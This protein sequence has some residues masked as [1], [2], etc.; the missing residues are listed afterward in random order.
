MAPAKGGDALTVEP[1]EEKTP[2]ADCDVCDEAMDLHHNATC[3]F[4]GRVFHLTWDTRLEIRDCG[5]FDIDDQSLAL[6]FTCNRCVES[7]PQ[8]PAQPF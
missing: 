3:A 2:P 1:T 8:R 7:G 4:C 6:Y 5:R